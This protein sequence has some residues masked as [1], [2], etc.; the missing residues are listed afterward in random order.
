MLTLQPGPKVF[1]KTL[2]LAAQTSWETCSSLPMGR[3]LG[4]AA[5]KP[6]YRRR[7][8]SPVSW[9]RRPPTPWM[10]LCGWPILAPSPWLWSTHGKTSLRWTCTVT[11]ATSS[12][13][14]C[15]LWSTLPSRTLD[16][17]QKASNHL[18]TTLASAATALVPMWPMAMS[19]SAQST[20]RA[21]LT[22]LR[23]AKVSKVH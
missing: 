18:L 5:A 21:T 20:T 9:L 23:D 15:P 1:L 10:K 13:W 14:V 7:R 2:P 12:Q 4:V 6:P 22:S 3:A 16:A 8:R 17:R 11:L 19:A